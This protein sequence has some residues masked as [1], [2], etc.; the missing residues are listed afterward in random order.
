M[1]YAK[2][3]AKDLL[4][5]PYTFENLQQ[6]NP[7]TS[8]D[9]RYNLQDWYKQTDD[10]IKNS[11]TLVFVKELPIPAFNNETHKVVKHQVPSLIDGEWALGW[12]VLEKTEQDIAAT[13]M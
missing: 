11:T 5:Y 13:V 3:K 9:L 2:V 1:Y 7:N 10:S 6:E 8:Y 12:D 4:V